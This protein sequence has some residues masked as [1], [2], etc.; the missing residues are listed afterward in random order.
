[1]MKE[2]RTGGSF[3][4]HQDYGYFYENGCIFPEMAAIFIPI[5]Q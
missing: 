3:L 4:W 1:M 2:P 5:D